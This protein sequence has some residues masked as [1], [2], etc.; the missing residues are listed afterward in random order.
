MMRVGTE[1]RHKESALTVDTFGRSAED[2]HR[3]AAGVGAAYDQV[4]RLHQTEHS[5]AQAPAAARM[6][7]LEVQFCERLHN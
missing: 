6:P 5:R 3:E 4:S 2:G 1:R 7:A